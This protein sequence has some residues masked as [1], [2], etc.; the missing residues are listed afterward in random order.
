MTPVILVAAGMIIIWIGMTD[1]LR[2]VLKQAKEPIAPGYPSIPFLPYA[3][4]AGVVAAPLAMLHDSEDWAWK[5]V[6][7]ILVMAVVVNY[8]GIEKFATDLK[9]FYVNPG[10]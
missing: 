4:A 2:T 10:G 5:Y 3:V 9:K 1:S 6:L 8:E 7:L